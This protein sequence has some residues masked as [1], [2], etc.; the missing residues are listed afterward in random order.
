MGKASSAK[1]VARAAGIGG[2]RA[3]GTRPPWMYYA[4]VAL[5][6]LL[7]VIGVFNAREF[8]TNQIN[9]N[10]NTPPTVGQSPPWY[11]GFAVEACGKLLPPIQTNKNP[12]GITT[13]GGIIYISPT[14][15]SAAGSNATLGKLATSIGMTLNAAQVQVPGGK[16]YTDG[17]TCEGKPG[18]VYVMTWG[19]PAM[20]AS[21]GT[22]Q[23]KKTAQDPC[24]PDCASGVL[25]AD[26]QLVTVAFL[27]APPSGQA[28]S[29]LQPPAS[30]IK[31]LAQLEA[32]AATSATTTTAP[33]L[34]T[35]T[36]ARGAT[37]T[38]ARGAT[39]TS[40]PGAT[41]TTSAP[42]ATT[43]TSARGA[44]TTSARGATTTKAGKTPHTT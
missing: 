19:N 32:A 36:S 34:P 38:S 22:L 15:K 41:T 33:V 21:D 12:Y 10:G 7:G 20:P 5:L 39:T 2:S 18:H 40:A 37:T 44:T 14:V 24:S 42:G 4:G 23:N 3:Y 25:L 28:Q 43:T 17:Q 9:K 1:K 8:R 6:V 26:D 13:R 35:T 27:P 29:V 30:V 11:E 31:K 16:L